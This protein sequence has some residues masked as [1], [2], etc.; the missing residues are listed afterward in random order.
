MVVHARKAQ[1]LKRQNPQLL[2]RLVD[3]DFAALDLS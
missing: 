3:T 2:N 1:I